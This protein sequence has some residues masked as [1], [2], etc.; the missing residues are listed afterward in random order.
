MSANIAGSAVTA[1][2]A[3][4]AAQQAGLDW[5]VSLAE[6]EALAVSDNGVSRLKVPDRFATIRTN[7][8]GEQAALGTVG[9]R[10]KVFQNGEMFSALDALVD[11]GEARYANAGE[12]R[13]GAQV[14]MLLELPRE[15][16]IASDP[17]AAYLLARTSHDGSCS[18]GVTPVVN[19]LFCSNQISGIFRKD[20]KYSLQ[21]TTNARLQVEQMRTM[22][23]VIY[24]GIE[25]YETIADKLLNDPVNDYQVEGMFRR[26]W[27]LPSTI[28]KTPYNKL[29]TG[30]RRTY[31]RVT[32]ARNTAFNIYKHSSTQ[33]NI[34]G[35]AFGAF[36]AI[37][38]YLDWNSHKSEATRAERVISGKYDKL[39]SKALDVVQL[40]GR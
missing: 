1:T 9:T 40:I 7:K 24:T 37:V 36:Q 35:T 29:S 15:V 34:R 25:S 33:E 8:D 31:N 38:E 16:K 27:T 30:E 26:M 3:Q 23:S 18:L 22:L 12:L 10:Y 6:L 20:C 32:D 4:D 28:E 17:H 39:K 11:S 5:H 2:S 14:W 13:G 19:R 21:H